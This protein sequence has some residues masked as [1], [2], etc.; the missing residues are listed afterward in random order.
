M[1]AGSLALKERFTKRFKSY[2]SNEDKLNV[3][4][5]PLTNQAVVTNPPVQSIMQGTKELTGDKCWTAHWKDKTIWRRKKVTGLNTRRRGRQ[6]NKGGTHEG[7]GV[8]TH[9]CRRTL[10]KTRGIRHK[11]IPI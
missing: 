9:T 6:L 5:Y 2:K 8:I 3:S 7:G 11:T 1:A 4:E 10:D